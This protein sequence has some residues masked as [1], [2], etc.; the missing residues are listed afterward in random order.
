MN[1]FKYTS[2]TCLDTQSSVDLVPYPNSYTFVSISLPH[3]LTLNKA[4]FPVNCHLEHCFCF[5][6]FRNCRCNP[7]MILVCKLFFLF[8]LEIYRMDLSHPSC[9]PAS[10]CIWVFLPHLSL[11]SQNFSI[12][13]SSLIARYTSLKSLLKA[14]ISLYDTYLNEF[15]S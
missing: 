1:A 14:F 7:S 6:Y 8:L 13:T 15:L 5:R 3:S 9:F 2:P 11:I 10:Y 4:S 12:A